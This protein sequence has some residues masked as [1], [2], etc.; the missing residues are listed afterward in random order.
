MFAD[1]NE[2][3]VNGH[4]IRIVDETN[5]DGDTFEKIGQVRILVD[6][7]D[8]ST[9]SPIRIRPG[10]SDS[11][12][13][14]GFI[15]L[16]RLTDRKTG[17]PELVLSQSLGADRYRLLRLSETGVVSVDTFRRSET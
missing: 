8:Y 11:N 10:Y 7:K 3:T 17:R 1:A 14:T 2:A 4:S 16:S 12:R 6:G 13:Y 5:S 15:H 9:P